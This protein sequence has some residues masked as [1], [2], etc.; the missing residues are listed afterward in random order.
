[1]AASKIT[2][3]DKV[4]IIAKATHINQVW[5]DDMNEIKIKV[6]ANADITDI[7]TSD[8]D[9]NKTDISTNT[10]DISTNASDIATINGAKS[11]MQTFTALESITNIVSPDTQQDVTLNTPT[12]DLLDFTFNGT[13]TFTYTGVSGKDILFLGAAN[14]SITTVIAPTTVVDV[15]MVLKY[16]N[17]DTVITP[18]GFTREDRIAAFAANYLFLNIQNGDEFKLQ[19]ECTAIHTISIKSLYI[20]LIQLK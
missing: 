11:Y 8:I 9:T 1:M 20:Q 3:P 12:V 15:T 2:Y 7:N 17:V 10:T 5:D 13:N 14:E 6:N 18:V 4:G 16:N 19:I